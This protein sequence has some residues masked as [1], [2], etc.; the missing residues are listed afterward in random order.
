MKDEIGAHWYLPKVHT[1]K[2]VGSTADP[3]QTPVEKDKGVTR[4]IIMVKGTYNT[5]VLDPP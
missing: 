1:S 5:H 2:G 4:Y 3:P